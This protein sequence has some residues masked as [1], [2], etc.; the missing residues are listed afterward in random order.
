MAS[1]AFDDDGFAPDNSPPPPPANE[2][3]GGVWDM[4]D[5]MLQGVQSITPTTTPE[6]LSVVPGIGLVGMG[7][8]T[9]PSPTSQ[10][11]NQ[12]VSD[13]PQFDASGAFLNNGL[14]ASFVPGTNKI[15]IAST[16]KQV[17]AKALALAGFFY[18]DVGLMKSKK[19]KLHIA[20]KSTITSPPLYPL[21][22]TLN[23]PSYHS[24]HTTD[25]IIRAYNEAV[26]IWQAKGDTL[27]NNFLYAEVV[28]RLAKA[29]T[30]NLPRITNVS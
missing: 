26:A 8:S 16:K 2:M 28:A 10:P 12:V 21:T 25:D 29:G 6:T 14:N 7:P 1:Q 24:C 4:L 9:G 11:V 20:F 13:L 19:G 3:G 27:E 17:M 30:V 15:I 22:L 5:Q 23:Q 18:E